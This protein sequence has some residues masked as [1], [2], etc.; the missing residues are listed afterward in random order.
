MIDLIPEVFW[1]RYHRLFGLADT[2]DVER[3]QTADSLIVW[4][5]CLAVAA[6]L[7][8]A[9][10]AFLRRRAGRSARGEQRPDDAA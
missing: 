8:A 3:L 9:V 7:V 1:T 5:V 10:A 4:A 6:A 2:G